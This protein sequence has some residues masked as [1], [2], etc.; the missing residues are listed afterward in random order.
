M[1]P[2]RLPL[3][4]LPNDD[5]TTRVSVRGPDPVPLALVFALEALPD[6]AR[7]WIEPA[8]FEDDAGGIR[9]ELLPDEPKN[10]SE[11]PPPPP[12]PPPPTLRPRLRLVLDR[13]SEEERRSEPSK[14]APNSLT[15]RTP[16]VRLGDAAGA[17]TLPVDV[18]AL[19][20]RLI[21]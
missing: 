21:A 11:P 4:T 7:F 12:P 15:S 6:L 13:A 16:S 10:P 3:P 2:P 19:A 8:P 20:L 18:A 17:C 1:R 9:E 14:R 5:G